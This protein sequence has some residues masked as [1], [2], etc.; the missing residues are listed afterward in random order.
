MIEREPPTRA[1]LEA[2]REA[3]AGKRQ[4]E[5]EQMIGE[6]RKGREWEAETGGQWEANKGKV[7]SK[8]GT[9][10][11]NKTVVGIVAVATSEDMAMVKS[12][13]IPEV[14]VEI[15]FVAEQALALHLLRA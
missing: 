15:C 1:A 5:L 14:V 11:L 13:S 10:N 7:E 3:K 8:T 9:G 6:E 2:E 4:E 12:N